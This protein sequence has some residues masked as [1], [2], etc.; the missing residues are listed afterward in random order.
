MQVFC[1]PTFLGQPRSSRSGEEA[2]VSEFAAAS[3]D[4]SAIGTATA[5]NIKRGMKRREMCWRCIA[6]AFVKIGVRFVVLACWVT[7]NIC[8][9]G[10][11]LRIRGSSDRTEGANSFPLQV[12]REYMF[13][14]FTH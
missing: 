4:A 6:K 2:V 7:I 3:G 12:V 14:Y 5:L 11:N 9:L 8:G 10:E 13:L 1:C